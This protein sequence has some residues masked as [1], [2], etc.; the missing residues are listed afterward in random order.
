MVKR[1]FYEILENY[2][3]DN[4]II[5]RNIVK[6]ML[7]SLVKNGHAKIDGQ[8]Y[9]YDL[10]WFEYLLNIYNKI[11]LFFDFYYSLKS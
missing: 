3:I 8:F 4:N 11:N 1:S 5:N 2:G 6:C 7:K 9:V 10:N